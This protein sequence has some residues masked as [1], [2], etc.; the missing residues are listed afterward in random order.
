MVVE[1]L[2]TSEGRALKSLNMMDSE[3][4]KAMVFQI[5]NRMRACF[6]PE[7]I[8][9]PRPK[10]A[11]KCNIGMGAGLII[12]LLLTGCNYY[13]IINRL[14]AFI[15]G[16]LEAVYGLLTCMGHFGVLDRGPDRLLLAIFGL[17]PI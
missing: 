7:G 10:S 4:Y 17:Y 3:T 6:R 13:I 9:P 11:T 12:I 5:E 2:Y 16:V 8:G 1:G 15:R 14:G